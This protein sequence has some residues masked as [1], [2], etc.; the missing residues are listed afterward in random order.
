[1]GRYQKSKPSK[2][3]RAKIEKIREE[4]RQ[5]WQQQQQQPQQ[6][7]IEQLEEKVEEKEKELEERMEHEIE[8]SEKILVLE[9]KEAVL[10]K[11][12]SKER[13]MIGIQCDIAAQGRRQ[14]IQL[15]GELHTIKISVFNKDNQL[16]AQKESI[17]N[18][19]D[20][21]KEKDREVGELKRLH[22]LD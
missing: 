8:L 2:K 15:E 14:I 17:R 11:G 7:I 13:R 20:Q 22:G 16:N 6:K 21:L 4:R 9:E 10:Q 19:R 3:V 12:L 5:R 1:M 18:L